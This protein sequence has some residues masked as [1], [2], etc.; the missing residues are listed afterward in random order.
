MGPLICHSQKSCWE[1]C[2][3]CDTQGAWGKWFPVVMSQV[4]WPPEKP[5]GQRSVPK[6]QG[7]SLVDME[8]APSERALGLHE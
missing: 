4:A 5:L 3:G 6:P 7:P 2:A 1:L 8:W